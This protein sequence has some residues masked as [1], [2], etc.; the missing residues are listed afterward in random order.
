MNGASRS[1][2][3]LKY[4]PE[5]MTIAWVRR[6]REMRVIALAVLIA[7]FGDHRLSRS[8]QFAHREKAIAFRLELGDHRLERLGRVPSPPIGMGHHDGAGMRVGQD[9]CRDGLRRTF[10]VGVA[11]GIGAEL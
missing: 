2:E 10:G 1:V 11:V 6:A 4:G 8:D 3:A 7:R 5:F 9:R